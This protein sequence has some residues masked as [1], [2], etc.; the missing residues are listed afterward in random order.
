MKRLDY[1]KKQR[2]R[3]DLRLL[4]NLISLDY[5]SVLLTEDG[6][7]PMGLTAMFTK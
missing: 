4:M 6:A 5:D 1:L 3:S 7:Q 2:R